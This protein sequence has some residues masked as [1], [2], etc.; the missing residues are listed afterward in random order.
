MTTVW[1]EWCKF[2]DPRQRGMLT[3]PFDPGCYELRH[4]DSGKLIL[5]GTGGHVAFRVT[6]LLP[7]PLG[8][9]GR[10]N[11]KKRTYVLQHIENIEYRTLACITREEA[12]ARE[13]ELKANKLAY[14][15]RT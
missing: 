13:K 1:S 8:Q 6:S 14:I 10:D 2:P 3:A 11:D 4:S 7:E 9:G 12:K 5:F 15:F